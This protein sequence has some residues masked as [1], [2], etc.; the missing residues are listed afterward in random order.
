MKRLGVDIP[1][2]ST[3]SIARLLEREVD[4][5][6]IKQLVSV[7]RGKAPSVSWKSLRR[8]L[9]GKTLGN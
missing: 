7:N 4:A 3:D 8:A 2:S 5:S 1:V 9:H 6:A